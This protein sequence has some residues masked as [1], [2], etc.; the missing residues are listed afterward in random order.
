[1]S[2]RWQGSN[3]P[4]T[5]DYIGRKVFRLKKAGKKARE[6]GEEYKLAKFGRV[7][8]ALYAPDG[9]HLVGFIVKRPD[10]AGMIKRPDAFVAFDV[11]ERDGKRLVIVSE[12]DGM[13]DDALRRLGVRWDDC[14]I[15]GGMD[16]VTKGGRKLGYVDGA[17]FDAKTGEVESFSITDGGMANAIIGC[18]EVPSS[19]VKG[20]TAGKM[21]VSN[22]AA[23]LQPSGGLAGKAGEAT[24]RAQQGAEKAGDVA[25]E[26]LDKGSKSLGK[27]IGK[28]KRAAEKHVGDAR[29][30]MGSADDV[31]KTVGKQLGRARG[32]FDAF[33][34]EFKKASK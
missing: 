10:V 21:L 5:Q 13:D 30:R 7:R 16:V 18:V 25:A 11:L 22:K 24:A 19:M 28:A 3:V 32:M 6:A 26:A 17:A 33:Q 31:A 8:Q 27:T 14:I 4:K 23:K 9:R 2:Y 1:M 34:E 20:Y 12:M 15:W 29:E